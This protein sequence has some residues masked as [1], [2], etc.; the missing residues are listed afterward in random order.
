MRPVTPVGILAAKLESLVQQLAQVE[1]P[2]PTFKVELQQA[3]ELPDPVS[4][5]PKGE[6]FT[7][8]KGATKT[9]G[10]EGWADVWRKDC[11]A[12]EYKGKRRDLTAAY[13]Q[14]Q[15]YAVALDNP[16][17]LIVSDMD[18]IRIHTN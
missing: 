16:P 9:T 18:R 8:E 13:A 1:S 4:D 14:L 12:W 3:Y 7:F 5:D 15:Q 17:L 10:G 11:F 2:N 6:R